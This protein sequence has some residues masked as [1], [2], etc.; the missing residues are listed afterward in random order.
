MPENKKKIFK[1]TSQHKLALLWAEGKEADLKKQDALL[2]LRGGTITATT[3]S[4]DWSTRDW[5]WNAP[6]V[7]AF[8]ND[9][10]ERI[11]Y[12]YT[13]QCLADTYLRMQQPNRWNNGPQRS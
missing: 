8:I 13:G 5:A 7:L 9:E 10:G 11:V 4:Y 3:K 6:V 12:N 1:V 2:Q